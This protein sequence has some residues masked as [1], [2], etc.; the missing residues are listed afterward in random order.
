[1]VRN[2][3]RPKELSKIEQHTLHYAAEKDPT[4]HL[5]ENAARCVRHNILLR[6][7]RI[8]AEHSIALHTV[9]QM[10]RSSFWVY[11]NPSYLAGGTGSG[12]VPGIRIVP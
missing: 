11:H 8:N 10:Q 12:T 5:I 6:V 7:D 9:T 1:M 3:I 2:G 4:Q